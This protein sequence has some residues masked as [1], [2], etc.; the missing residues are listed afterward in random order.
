MNS[1]IPARLAMILIG[2]GIAQAQVGFLHGTV[3]NGSGGI[4]PSTHVEVAS[5]T[6]R[7]AAT[8]DSQGRFNCELPE[9]VYLLKAVGVNH[10]EYRR[11]PIR[12]L[13][14]K[15]KFIVIQPVWVAPSD[16]DLIKDPVLRYESLPTDASMSVLV[17]FESKQSEIGAEVFRGEH[18]MLSY[19]D[20]TVYAKEIRCLNPV[21][22]THLT[23]PTILRV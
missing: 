12:V 17:Q 15:H 22:Y 23:L 10:I 14:S 4:V 5:A 18:L 3:R 6:A 9:G 16:Q 2:T 13:P 7:C 1:F 20:L 19:D 8:S 11:A 21:S